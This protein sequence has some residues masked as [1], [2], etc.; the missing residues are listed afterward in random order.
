MKVE[1]RITLALAFATLAIACSPPPGRPDGGTGGGGGGTADACNDDD[2][3]PRLFRCSRTT[4]TCVPDCATSAECG[5]TGRT[6]KGATAL[7]FC[8]TDTSCVCDFTEAGGEC[9]PKLCSADS[10]CGSSLVCRSG[11]CVAAPLASTV[12]R[13]QVTPDFVVAKAGS[14]MRFWVSAWAGQEPVVI[15]DGATW[16]APAMSPFSAPMPATGTSAE[17]TVGTVATADPMGVS[18]VQAAFGGVNCTAKAI[19]VAA[20]ASGGAVVAIDELSGRPISGARVVVSDATGAVIA[21]PSDVSTNDSG[22]GTFTFGTATSYTVSV[23][24]RDFTYVTVANY[25]PSGA[26]ANVLLVAMR[27]NQVTKYG[28]FRGTFDGYPMNPN[29]K[30]GV[31]GMS[32]AG[33][34]TNLNLTQLLGPSRSTRIKLGSTIDMMVDVPDGAFLVFS[35]TNKNTLAGL[36]LN[37]SCTDMAGNADEAKIR[38]GTCGTRAAW[39]FSGELTIGDLSPLLGAFQGGLDNI[40]V[41]ALLGQIQPLIRRLNSSIVRDIQFDLRDA[42][43]K[44]SA[45]TAPNCTKGYKYDDTSGFTQ[46]NLKWANVPLGFGFALKSARMPTYRGAAADGALALT[47]VTVPGR[48]VIPL[49]LGAAVNTATPKDDILDKQET[50]PAAGLIPVRSAP[51]HSG[52][53]GSEYGIIVAALSASALND[54]SAQTGASALFVRVPDNKLVFDPRGATPIDISSQAYPVFP[55]SGRFNPAATGIPGV[56]PRSFKF[57]TP[58]V[59]T[60]LGT[61]VQVV[62]VTFSDELEHRWDVFFDASRAG[63]GFSLPAV[64]ATLRDRLFTTGMSSGA[65]SPMVVQ[66]F[67]MSGA[68]TATGGAALSFKDLVE[69]NGTNM[70]RITNYLTGFGFLDYGVPGVKFKAAIPTSVTKGTSKVTVSVAKFKIGTAAGD[71][72]LVKFSFL[73]NGAPV[74]GCEVASSTE[75]MAGKGEVEITI[76]SACTAGTGYTAKAQL[77]Y[78]MT[79]PVLPEVS[80]TQTGVTVQ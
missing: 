53:E 43:C 16:T 9:K 34:I 8:A 29:I 26:N 32:L 18:A 70:D 66:A 76:P 46:R 49:G 59:V 7:D 22:L 61:S 23:F 38:A 30:A 28:G 50:L 78:D 12:T 17:F 39:A 6:A 15:K 45:E 37:G 20:P 35:E 42:P 4:N 11:Q 65:R 69:L 67:R 21:Q 14:K 79:A 51:S 58:S 77:F 10:D 31:G 33:A 19:V 40:N 68:P 75:A 44:D 48:G 5:P 3:C 80:V 56:G 54:A 41:G 47:G 24:H 62:R 64:P 73:N 13:C 2:Q 57:V 74:A 72:G 25:E 27:R 63:A 60:A 52:T 55:E 71:D 36:G 1:F